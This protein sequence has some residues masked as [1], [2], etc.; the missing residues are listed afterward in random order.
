MGKTVGVCS[1]LLKDLTH[2]KQFVIAM[3]LSLRAR[4]KIEEPAPRQSNQRRTAAAEELLLQFQKKSA[5]KTAWPFIHDL[6]FAMTSA[7]LI[8]LAVMIS[9]KKAKG[10]NSCLR[11]KIVSS[12]TNDSSSENGEI[13]VRKAISKMSSPFF[14]GRSRRLIFC[15]DLGMDSRISNNNFGHRQ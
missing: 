2:R 14:P 13:Y 12:W 9:S 7:Q 15:Q 8:F 4:V 6:L 10:G 5:E 1:K 3:L 11:I